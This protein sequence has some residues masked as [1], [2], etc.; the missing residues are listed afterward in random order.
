MT[1]EDLK[2][3][4]EVRWRGSLLRQPDKLEKIM[5]EHDKGKKGYLTFDDFKDFYFTKS[6]KNEN[7]IWKLINLSGYKNNLRQGTI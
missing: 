2:T 6:V 5:E 3:L 4:A 7:A 1:Y